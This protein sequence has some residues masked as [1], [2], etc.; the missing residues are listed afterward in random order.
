MEQIH[1]VHTQQKLTLAVNISWTRLFSH[2]S[3]PSDCHQLK[4]CN[5]AVRERSSTR[6]M[7][8]VAFKAAFFDSFG[9]Y[10]T[11]RPITRSLQDT[12]KTPGK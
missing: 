2:S 6:P 8:E 7:I 10:G 9:G 5:V 3:M 1:S 11:I 4:I 12:D